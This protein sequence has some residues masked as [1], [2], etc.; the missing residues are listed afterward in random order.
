MFQPN[1]L[2]V[3][4]IGC[5]SLHAVGMRCAGPIIC[6]TRS[7][8]TVEKKY[9]HFYQQCSPMGCRLPEI[10]AAAAA[11]VDGVFTNNPKQTR[12][13]GIK[14]SSFAPWGFESPEIET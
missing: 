8:G 3:E 2:W 9:N 11:V 10:C 6:T 5:V 4:N 12:D 1:I 7:A 14:N 13:T